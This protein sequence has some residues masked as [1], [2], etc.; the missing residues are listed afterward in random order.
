MYLMTQSCKHPLNRKDL[1]LC[2]CSVPFDSNDRCGELQKQKLNTYPSA[3]NPRLSNILS[4]VWFCSCKA[5]EHSGISKETVENS[6]N[7]LNPILGKQLLSEPF[8]QVRIKETVGNSWNILN[9]IL[10]NSYYQSHSNT[11]VSIEMKP[12]LVAKSEFD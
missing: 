12:K 9:P 3:E 10:R 2:Y 1:V 5:Q 4:S 8:K 6:W 11:L 7:F